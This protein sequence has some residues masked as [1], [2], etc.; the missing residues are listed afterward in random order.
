MPKLRFN[1]A[2]IRSL[3][4]GEYFDDLL[5]GFG[6]RV[7]NGGTR[8]FFVRYRSPVLLDSRGRKKNQRI[9]L[10]RYPE[11]SLRGARDRARA[12]FEEVEYGLDPNAEAT[13]GGEAMPFAALAAEYLERHARVKKKE[14]SWLED[15]RLIRKHL[16]PIWGRK[17]AGAITRREIAALLDAIVDG[18]APVMANRVRS[19]IHTIFNFAIGRGLVEKNPCHLLPKPTKEAPREYVLPDEE[20]A[21]LWHVLDFEHGSTARAFRLLLLTG[22]RSGEVL[23]MRYEQLQE[24]LWTLP[25]GATK[26][27]RAHVIPLSRQ[28]LAQIPPPMGHGYGGWVLPSP[29]V[30]G[31]RMTI[32]ALS[33]AA[34]RLRKQHGLAFRPHDLRRTVFTRLVEMGFR[35]TVAHRVMNHSPG[36][37]TRVYNLHDYLE[38][39]REALAAWG[40]RVE[41]IV[42]RRL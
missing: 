27:G 34:R 18:G 8:T 17:E 9:S 10:G 24:D 41:D 38:E 25:A 2:K 36:G 40:A 6:L 31:A 16:L 5:P 32:H 1:D 15:E 7:R 39:K 42:G 20:V 37:L 13:E 35:E 4:P 26:A 29:R 33:R 14:S 11:M 3:G 23:G 30:A 22:Q 19:L 21:Q 28:A 12:L